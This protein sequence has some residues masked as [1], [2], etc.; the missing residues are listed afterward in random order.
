MHASPFTGRLAR[1]VAGT[2]I[3]AVLAAC[4][5][6]NVLQSPSVPGAPNAAPAIRAHGGSPVNVAIPKV[7]KMHGKSSIKPSA[8]G[9]PLLYISDFI[10]G[11]VN[12][13]TWPSKQLVGTLYNA[14]LPRGM[15]VDRKHNVWIT[16]GAGGISQFAHGASAPTTT[17]SIPGYNPVGCAVDPKT[18]DLAVSSLNDIGGAQGTLTI[19][20]H[21][22]AP[23]T[24]YT[25]TILYFYDFLSYDNKG[26]LYIDGQDSS[27]GFRL[28]KFSNG[29]F[30]PITV[31]GATI[32]F[33]GGVQYTHGR[34]TVGDQAATGGASI[35]YRM[36]KDGTVT[37]STTLN[38]SM[39]CVQY[40]ISGG[41]LICPNAGGP[42]G[43]NVAVY[44][45][46]AGGDPTAMLDG[47]Y[48]LPIGAVVSK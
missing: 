7:H 31:S 6:G 9:G 24:N 11:I 46:P 40:Y 43:P 10:N 33:P 18:G 30:T 34:L 28:A 35:V 45:Y 44:N 39:D 26:N 29:T 25:D 36:R 5:G 47:S 22:S 4:S 23:G 8:K 15:C 48:V 37:G 1:A 13:Y 27:Y 2:A 38:A 41:S 3:A 32:N 12:V 20:P 16:D 42:T 14:G 21:A 17:L 19:F